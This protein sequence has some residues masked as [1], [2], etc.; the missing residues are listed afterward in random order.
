[1][2]TVAH[3]LSYYPGR[4][5]L[6]S[7]C[8]GLGVAFQAVD[9][10]SVPIITFRSKPSKNELEREPEVIKF[11]RRARH[12]FDIP[13]SFLSALDG[14]DLK[15][16]GAV[17]HGTYSPQAFAIAR[18]LYKRQLPYIFMPHDP[19]VKELRRHHAVRKFV[20]WH[21]CEKWVLNHAAAVQLL[22]DSHEAPLRELGVKVPVFTLANGCDPAD[23]I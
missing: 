9:G 22:S 19:Y 18:A 1:M 4:E 7:F 21:L 2:R 12:P 14:G 3:I 5:G 8:R 11:P 20:Y 15:L 6:T 16:D 23:L 17:L 10:W 13:A